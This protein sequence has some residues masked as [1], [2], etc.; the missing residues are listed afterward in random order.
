MKKYF[1]TLIISLSSLS[2]GYSNDCGWNGEAD[3]SNGAAA[4]FNRCFSDY[5]S[6]ESVYNQSYKMR[7]EAMAYETLDMVCSG[8]L[9]SFT[10]IFGDYYTGPE[11]FGAC[12][13][14]W[15]RTADIDSEHWSNV[16][17]A[18]NYLNRCVNT[19]DGDGR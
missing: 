18:I 8:W 4:C 3:R 11:Y 13:S 10:G 1:F 16:Q 7:L 19:C 14:I 9:Q 17:S 6:C 2:L 15:G 5:E 12:D